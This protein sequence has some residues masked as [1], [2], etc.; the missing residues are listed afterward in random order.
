MRSTNAIPP[1]PRNAVSFS[2]NVLI[3][4]E[5]IIAIRVIYFLETATAV[6]ASVW[7]CIQAIQV[8]RIKSVSFWKEISRREF[9]SRVGQ[10]ERHPNRRSIRAVENVI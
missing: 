1:Q 10:T 7:Y 3:T 5:W 4:I 9:S 6:R 8:E 2:S